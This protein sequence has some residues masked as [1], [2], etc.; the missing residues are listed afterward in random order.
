MAKQYEK[1]VVPE[2]YRPRPFVKKKGETARDVKYLIGSFLGLVAVFVAKYFFDFWLLPR[3]FPDLFPASIGAL[4]LWLA[5]TLIFSIVALVFVSGIGIYYEIVDTIYAL[6]VLIW[7]LG[8]YGLGTVVPVLF[9]VLIA[10]VVMRAIQ[11]VL[12]WVMI[13]IG[14]MKM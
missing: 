2:K 10:W 3:L 7:P 4:L 13:L 12:L 6:I 14:L 8:L 1:F 5:S 11:W 9:G